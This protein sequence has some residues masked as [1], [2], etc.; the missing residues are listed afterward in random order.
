MEYELYHHGILGMKWGIRRYQRRDGSLTSLG[1]RHYRNKD[2]SLTEEGKN[3]YDSFSDDEKR[4]HELSKKNASQLSTQ[5]LQF[6]NNR[7]QAKNQYLSNTE[8]RASKIART[9]LTSTITELSKEYVKKGAKTLV[10]G[11]FM[12]K[13]TGSI[14]MRFFDEGVKY[15]S[16]SDKSY[17]IAG[18]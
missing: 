1:R 15:L 13:K 3:Y 7:L 14:D 8:S 2:G 6:M 10:S 4:F 5:E 17:K 18:K 11:N 9:V 16:K 12:K